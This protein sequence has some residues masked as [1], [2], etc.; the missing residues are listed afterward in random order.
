MNDI[1]LAM[2]DWI[3]LTNWTTETLVELTMLNVINMAKLS[4]VALL[5]ES[6]DKSLQKGSELFNDIKEGLE[7]AIAYSNG[8]N[9]GAKVMSKESDNL[10]LSQY[11]ENLDIN[12]ATISQV[13][14]YVSDYIEKELKT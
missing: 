9:T 13:I 10:T 1:E 14:E 12:F 2:K 3:K 6:S 5:S 11:L 4:V 7:E 8:K